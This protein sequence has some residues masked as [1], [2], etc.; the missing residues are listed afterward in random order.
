MYRFYRLMYGLVG[1]SRSQSNG[2]L[3]LLPLLV[4][5]LC[6]EPFFRWWKASKTLYHDDDVRKLDS[7][8][9]TWPKEKHEYPDSI[10]HAVSPVAFDPN[11]A[12]ESIMLKS[13]LNEYVINKIVNYREK[14]GRFKSRFDLLKIYGMD[15]ATFQK[16]EP[17]VIIPDPKIE[18]FKLSERKFG[19]PRKVDV[20]LSV[21]LNEAD[22]S[23]LKKISGIGE[24]LSLRIVRYRDALGGFISMRQLTEIYR[25]DSAIINRIKKSFFIKSEFVPKQL[26]INIAG[27]QDLATHPYISTKVADAIVA[28]RFQHGEF[29]S[30]EELRKIPMVDSVMFLKSIPYLKLGE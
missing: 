14:G 25:L 17:F 23:K 20:F 15:S 27:R 12:S 1:F 29:K 26:N 5:I 24:K 22:T 8:L 28:Y 21:D 11:S 4:I 18:K 16:I 9:A 7:L 30:F 19:E 6:S 13:G 10:R 2:F 3:I